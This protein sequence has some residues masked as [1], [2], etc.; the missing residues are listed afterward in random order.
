MTCESCE[1]QFLPYLYDL[2]DA[3]ERDELDAHLRECSHC[4]IELDRARARRADIAVAVK[5]SFPDVVF[6]TPRL[7]V[8]A[9]RTAPPP[10]GPRRP[11][12]LSRWA[13]AAAIIFAVMAVGSVAAGCM[14]YYQNSLV[15]SRQDALNRQRAELT[16]IDDQVKVKQAKIDKDIQEV[17]AQI[18]R[19]L[20]D[21]TNQVQKT[22]QDPRQKQ[23]FFE[24]TGPA[25]AQAGG[26]N[27]YSVQV[28]P[29]NPG[30]P[31]TVKRLSAEVVNA[32]TQEVVFKQVLTV[33]DRGPVVAPVDLPPDMPVKPGDD[34]ELVFHAD[35]ADGAAQVR[36]QLGLSF[37]DYVTYLSTDRPIYRPG[38]VMRFRSLTLE[39]FSFTPAREDLTLRYRITA[40]NNDNIDLFKSELSTRLVAGKDKKTVNGPD[41]QPL[42]GIGTGEF[43]LPRQLPGGV[44]TL[45]VSEANGR[46]PEEKRTFVVHRWQA[47][48]F[49]KE[50]EFHRPSYSPGDTVVVRGK[51]ARIAQQGA[52]GAMGA[53]MPGNIAAA[54]GGVGFVNPQG[55]A[56]PENI[57]VQASVSYNGQQWWANERNADPDG[58]FTFD[59]PVPQNMPLGNG[60]VTL[61]FSDNGMTE[62]MV[63]AIPIELR[64]VLLD[65]Y[66]E[67][68]DLVAGVPNRVYFQARTAAYKPVAV[69]GWLLERGVKYDAKGREILDKQVRDLAKI[70]TFNDAKAP[71][72][73]QGLG[74]VTFTPRMDRR[75]YVK[76]DTPVGNN[77]AYPVAAPKA[78]KDVKH[79]V[80]ADGVVLQAP[81]G[82][83]AKEIPVT[84]YSATRD[85]EL[86]VGAYCRGKLLDSTVVQ[87]RAGARTEVT[88]HP[89][90][91]V[92]GVYR[93]TVFDK[94]AQKNGP[95]AYRAAAERLVFR[96]QTAQ[97]HVDITPQRS[98]YTPGSAVTLDLAARNEQRQLVGSV[99]MCTVV[100]SSV[101]K[102]LG[103]KAEP[104]MP[105]HYLLTSEIRRPEDLENADALLNETNPRAAEALDLLLGTQG[106]R[107]FA[108]QLDSKQQ[109]RN[110]SSWPT[111]FLSGTRPVDRVSASGQKALD[112]I[113]Q[114]HVKEFFRLEAELAQKERDHDSIPE[115]GRQVAAQSAVN[116]A[117]NAV[118]NELGRL[119]DLREFFLYAAFAALVGLVVFGGFFLVATSLYRL[120]EGRGGFILMGI[121]LSVLAFLFITS[122]LGTF[123]LLG[124]PII[125][126]GII[127]QNHN[128]PFFGGMAATTM[129]APA[130]AP[131]PPVAF[132]HIPDDPR[133]QVDQPDAEPA[134][135]PPGGQPNGLIQ[136]PVEPN[137]NANQPNIAQ[138]QGDFER[139]LRQ[140]GNFRRLLDIKLGRKVNVPPPTD[141][142]VAREYA[143]RQK[144]NTNLAR[145]DFTE[146]I[147]WQPALVLKDGTG[148]VEFQLSDAATNFRVLAVSHT[149]DGRLGTDIMEFSSRLPYE[150]EPQLPVEI[151]AND[152]VTVPVAVTNRSNEKTDYKIKVLRADSLQS[153]PIEQ[154][155][156]PELAPGQSIR[157][158]FK[159]Q[160]TI[161]DGTAKL[162]LQGIFAKGTDTIERTFTIAP[163]GFP[164]TNSMS[165][166]LQ[167]Q[168][169]FST[170]APMPPD[171]IGGSLVLQLHAYPTVLADLQ[172]GL[173]ALQREAHGSFEQACSSAYPNVLLLNYLLDSH[174]VNPAAEARARERLAR[175]YQRLLT[176]ECTPPSDPKGH[177]GYEWFGQTAPPNEALTAYALLEFHDMARVYPVD[178]AMLERTR[179]FL[180]DQ[181]DGKGGFKRDARAVAAFGQ[182]PANIRNAY[183]VWALTEA[184][185]RDGGLKTELDSLYQQARQ[186]Q[187]PY[188]LALTALGQL[189]AGRAEPG[190]ELLH[191]VRQ[192]DTGEVAGA[193]TSITNST[194]HDLSIETTALSALA[195]QRAARPKE[196][197]ANAQK[198]GQWLL[199]QRS[200]TGNFGATQATVLTLKALIAL[201]GQN[202][203][204]PNAI[205]PTDLQVRITQ[206]G[207]HGVSRQVRLT[208]GMNEVITIRLKEKPADEKQEYVLAPG[209]N[210]IDV[211][212]TGGNNR[213]PFALSWSYR[214]RKPQASPVTPVQVSTGLDKAQVTEG[215]TVKLHVGLENCSGQDQGMAV[216]VIGLPAGLSLPSDR[217]LKELAR[218]TEDGKPGTISGWE[219]RGSRELVLYWRALKADAKIKLDLDVAARQPGVFS[220]PA[221]RA[222]LYYNAEHKHWAD[223]LH[224]MVKATP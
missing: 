139:Q 177:R 16:R 222:Y 128:G 142:S 154:T 150:V 118:G 204:N 14:Y 15:A 195:W 111:A 179:K 129:K 48:R 132:V 33:S 38:E 140:Q 67:G 101:F 27:H 164:I 183:I 79:V 123:A 149:L 65:F 198:A 39:R 69:S 29:T 205:Q 147:C 215:D 22:K 153:L 62:T 61:Q 160:P 175:D 108:E 30:Q 10:R 5:S 34:L 106:W 85:R 136:V 36:E 125:N 31:P 96:K 178:K 45:R 59:F 35:L 99:V 185:T 119:N 94:Q 166:T 156:P 155:N 49:N 21:W 162:R 208:P 141:A 203:P 9:A 201:G 25:T 181:R 186:S 41:G 52:Q 72:L 194:G 206:P 200:G 37:P 95:P 12:L 8:K 102:L 216:A 120:A 189:N 71:A 176:F 191:R 130:P 73:N 100:D 210:Q 137:A 77:K 97:L 211:Q 6:K 57:R 13:M 103:D 58:S 158:L 167:G 220:G 19:L 115:R 161:A 47:P 223:P 112:R 82:V 53:G 55:I 212:M 214:M 113:D 207:G 76:L 109:Q 28:K 110:R 202:R 152:Q 87:A 63:R 174:Q 70:E 219:K 86:L 196:F 221:S 151:A 199:Q 133:W 122:V 51:V 84:I 180:L 116:A 170:N 81:R 1:K 173:D 146:T 148:K 78:G 163:D 40:P 143:H 24:I 165:G 2:L 192:R 184:G 209:N 172:Q 66:P 107:R 60:L 44:Y 32:K 3:A 88:L 190:V 159:F 18:D 20:G 83:V 126:N 224:V 169:A 145:R 98:D 193:R 42:R 74:I 144:P 46:F 171:W 89:A 91:D 131:P 104:S 56:G 117:S 17:Q 4:Q 217:Q 64:D 68:G 26:K 182:P 23:V 80:K 127:G 54:P 11:L 138:G 218:L 92:G 135:T 197:Q 134:P 75:Y 187:D 7:L 50:A 90:V 213:L 188:F 105:A 114:E 43:T 93:I 124:S 168:A 157:K 121:G